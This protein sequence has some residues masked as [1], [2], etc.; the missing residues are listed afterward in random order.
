MTGQRRRLCT[1]W[2]QGA[3]AEGG[4]G[5]VAFKVGDAQ[6]LPVKDGMFDVVLGDFITGLADDKE[7]AVSELCGWQAPAVQSGS[8]KPPG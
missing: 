3:S 8:M 2:L 1:N 5:R 7:G 6:K 4:T